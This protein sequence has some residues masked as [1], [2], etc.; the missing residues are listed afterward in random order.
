MIFIILP[1]LETQLFLNRYN[2][3]YIWLRLDIVWFNCE[4][5]VVSIIKLGS[6]TFVPF[7]KY[8][9]YIYQDHRVQYIF[10]KSSLRTEYIAI[11][12]G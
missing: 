3:S 5:D 12:H 6:I 11:H 7:L 9:S 2:Y 10:Q 1:T 4:K 8:R